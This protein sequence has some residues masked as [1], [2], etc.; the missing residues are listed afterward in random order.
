MRPLALGSF[1]TSSCI[2]LHPLLPCKSSLASLL[3]KDHLTDA[4]EKTVSSNDKW[5]NHALCQSQC[6]AKGRNTFLPTHI[7]SSATAR[8]QGTTAVIALTHTLA[9]IAGALTIVTMSA[10]LP[11][12]P[13]PL[14][15]ALFHSTTSMWALFVPPP[16]LL[17]TTLMSLVLLLETMM[18]ILKGT[19]LTESRGSASLGGASCYDPRTCRAPIFIFPCALFPY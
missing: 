2:V 1:L 15:N 7:V 16:S 3:L 6:W 9:D 12:S 8:T 17:E 11:T 10:P 5:S 18:E 14:P 13:A 19:S 4:K